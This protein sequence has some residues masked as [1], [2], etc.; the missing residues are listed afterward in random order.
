[1]IQIPFHNEDTVSVDMDMPGRMIALP[2]GEHIPSS[3]NLP[4][5]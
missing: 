4:Y 2:G 5:V 3:T 1:M